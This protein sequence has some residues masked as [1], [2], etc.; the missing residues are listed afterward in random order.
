MKEN[1]ITIITSRDDDISIL[2]IIGFLDAHTANSLENAIGKLIREDN[3]KIICDCTEIEYISSAGFGVFM[4]FIEELRAN[5]G[6]L[7]F[8]GLS[9]KLKNLF[10]LLGFNVLFEVNDDIEELKSNFTKE[11]K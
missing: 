10:D 7:K 11:A 3:F 9:P 5:G 1:E 6:D 4:E 8:T 2:Q